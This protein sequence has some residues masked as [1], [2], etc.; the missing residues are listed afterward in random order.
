MEIVLAI[1]LLEVLALLFWM[2]SRHYFRTLQ[3][4]RAGKLPGAVA[5]VGGRNMNSPAAV[6]EA[7][8]WEFINNWN[9]TARGDDRQGLIAS[10][11]DSG[12]T[13][14]E[15]RSARRR[16]QQTGYKKWSQERHD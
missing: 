2:I 12:G 3:E 6:G 13:L 8:H 14:S 7:V 4:N 11:Q 5:A 1:L 16:S 9:L 10:T 15:R